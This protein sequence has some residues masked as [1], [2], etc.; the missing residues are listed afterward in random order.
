MLL[1]IFIEFQTDFKIH[2]EKKLPN[3]KATMVLEK[4]TK[5]EKFILL[6]IKVY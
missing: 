2:C 5:K 6:N 4:K 1:G 3:K